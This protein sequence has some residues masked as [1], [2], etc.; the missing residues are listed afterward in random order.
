MNKPTQEFCKDVPY[1]VQSNLQRCTVQPANRIVN[2]EYSYNP[3]YEERS[4]GTVPHVIK[5]K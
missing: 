1:V 5:T 2:Y 4:I 3:L